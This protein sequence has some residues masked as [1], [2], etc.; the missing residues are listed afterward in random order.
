MIKGCKNAAYL[1]QDE[2]ETCSYYLNEEIKLINPEILAPLGYYATGYIFQKY[3]ILLP[4]K[5]EFSS[6][7]GGLF[8]TKDKKILPLPHPASLLYSPDFKQDLMKSYRKLQ[9][10]LKDCKWYPVCPMERFYEEGGLDKKWIE[11]YC[12][13]DWQSCI[14]YQMVEKGKVQPDWMLP[15][16]SLDEKLHNS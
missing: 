6:I 4:L 11:L 3:D 2:I 7:Y 14:R 9:M 16:G 5:A 12:K 10:L 15:D 13:R 1:K 8:L